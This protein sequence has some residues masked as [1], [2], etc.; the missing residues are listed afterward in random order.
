MYRIK[1]RNAAGS[2]EKI[3]AAYKAHNVPYPVTFTLRDGR[4]APG[5]S[6]ATQE[7]C[8]KYI[9]ATFKDA[10]RIKVKLHELQTE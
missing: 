9:W 8:C 3:L 4:G 7:D 2:N 10:W 1:F 5:P 6:M